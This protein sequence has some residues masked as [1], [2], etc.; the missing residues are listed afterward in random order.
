LSI[1]LKNLSQQARHTPGTQFIFA[2][3]L[4]FHLLF[5]VLSLSRS[6]V[7]P[8]LRLSFKKESEG[9]EKKSKEELKKNGEGEIVGQIHNRTKRSEGNDG[10]TGRQTDRQT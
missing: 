8:S 3:P 6:G 2:G 7:C 4:F 9:K 1:N 10:R 5:V